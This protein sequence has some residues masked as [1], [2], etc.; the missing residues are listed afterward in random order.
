MPFWLDKPIHPGGILI[1]IVGT[2]M[3]CQGHLYKE[4]EICGEV[5]KED[6][7]VLLHK[8]QLMVEG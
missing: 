5:L 8:M 4:N 7:V 3:S 2:T 1:D 6:M